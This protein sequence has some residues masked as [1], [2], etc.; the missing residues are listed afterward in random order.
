MKRIIYIFML[1]LII[2]QPGCFSNTKEKKEEPQ[3]KKI[4]VSSRNGVLV[5]N[6]SESGCLPQEL[7]RGEDIRVYYF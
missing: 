5:L 6:E 2:L 3:I 4:F 1:G 7:I